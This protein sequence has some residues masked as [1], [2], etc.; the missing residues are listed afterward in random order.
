MA[1]PV[2]TERVAEELR[3]KARKIAHGLEEIGKKLSEDQIPKL[4]KN[5]TVISVSSMLVYSLGLSLSM[6]LPTATPVFVQ[7]GMVLGYMVPLMFIF[8]SMSLAISIMKLMVK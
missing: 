4:M 6:M 1:E 3:D 8:M 5:I 7:F 2:Q